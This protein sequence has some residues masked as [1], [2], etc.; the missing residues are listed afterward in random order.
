MGQAAIHDSLRE[1]CLIGSLHGRLAAGGF[2]PFGKLLTG[3]VHVFADGRSKSRRAGDH[4]ALQG[5]PC[6]AMTSRPIPCK[7]PASSDPPIHTN[8]LTLAHTLACRR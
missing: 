2:P 3:C 4:A 1:F 5:D 8:P 7:A 6:P